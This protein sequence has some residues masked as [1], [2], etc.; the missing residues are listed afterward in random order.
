MEAREQRNHDDT[1]MVVADWTLDPHAVVAACVRD[2][3]RHGLPFELVVPAWLHGLDWVGDP[4]ASV[5]C[6]R[7]Q[8]ATLV[9]LLTSAGLR[10]AAAQ[11]GD[12]DPMGAI[13]D[14]L[15]SPRVGR[16]LLVTRQRRFAH[17]PLDLA[18]RA[19]RLSGLP[20]EHVA[21][22]AAARGRFRRPVGH[23]E[24]TERLAAAVGVRNRGPLTQ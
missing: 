3:E 12:P 21:V 9:A 11:V 13:A 6:A 20:V 1:V 17:H 8:V 23:C 2:A 19:A 10:L 15:E 14:A 18:H 4:A 5:P 22:R 24:A 16:I 7:R